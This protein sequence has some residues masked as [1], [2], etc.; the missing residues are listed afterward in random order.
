MYLY[1]C[2]NSVSPIAKTSSAFTV[3]FKFA[4]LSDFG[5]KVKMFGIVNI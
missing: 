3:Y 5:E 1:I 4:V 2:F